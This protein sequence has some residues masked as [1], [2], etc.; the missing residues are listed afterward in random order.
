MFFVM[1]TRVS[2]PLE[3]KMKVIEIRLQ[4]ISEKQVMDELQMKNRTQINVRLKW[5]R[6]DQ[7]HRLEQTVGKQ[8]TYGKGC[9]HQL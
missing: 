9:E 4:G 8:Y 2:Y 7:L 5:H 1:G 3:V 6:E